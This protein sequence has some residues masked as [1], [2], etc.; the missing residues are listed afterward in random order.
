MK[1]LSH[2][3][4]NFEEYIC[5]IMMAVMVVVVF[6]Q[7]VYRFVIQSSLP[8]SEE[9]ARYLLVWI[10]FLGASSGVKHGSHVGVEAVLLMLP[11]KARKY[12]N[13]LSAGLSIFFSIVV[14]VFSM[15][16][17]S[18]QIEM[19]QVSPAMQI[20]MWWAYAAIPVGA[21]LMAVRYVQSA[22]AIMKNK[23]VV[24]EEVLL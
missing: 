13:L 10:T 21:T 5:G 9:V 7:V 8:W 2:F 19:A 24:G 3:F 4:K 17:I 23:A 18:K 20:P 1:N 12:V 15:G 16:I 14:V 22:I 11:Q 6:I